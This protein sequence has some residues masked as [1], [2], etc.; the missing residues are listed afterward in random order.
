MKLKTAKN[1]FQCNKYDAF[2]DFLSNFLDNIPT[3]NLLK[4]YPN[5]LK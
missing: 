1:I 4:I 5:F 2:S 3:D